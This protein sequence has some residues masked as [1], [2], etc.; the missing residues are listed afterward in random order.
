MA[1]EV[2][3][4]DPSNEKSD[5]YSFG[6]ILWELMA[7]QQPWSDL[8]PPQV[9]ISCFLQHVDV[10]SFRSTGSNKF[11]SYFFSME[12][13]ISCFSIFSNYGLNVSQ[14]VYFQVVAAVGFKG[15]RLEIPSSVDPKVAAIIESCWAKYLITYLL[16]C[17]F[18]CLVLGSYFDK[19]A[20]LF[21]FFFV[22]SENPGD[23]PRLPVS[24]NPWNHL[25]RHY[26]PINSKRK[27]S[28]SS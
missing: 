15:R 4:D 27:I 2:L 25:S 20:S 8:N 28:H 24:W 16:L 18:P 7:L 13:H 14:P 12:R 6:V 5:V 17:F 11:W 26:H 22:F 10:F 21:S 19:T 9:C 23:D 3:R 1:P